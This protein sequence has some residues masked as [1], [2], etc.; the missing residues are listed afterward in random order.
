MLWY[1]IFHFFLFLLPPRTGRDG[2]GLSDSEGRAT[3]GW[4]S[5]RTDG[6]TDWRTDGRTDGQTGGRPQA[7]GG[8]R[9]TDRAAGLEILK[10]VGLSLES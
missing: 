7:G 2:C 8:R 3:D 9:R 6:R 5:G 1:S 10:I 4:P